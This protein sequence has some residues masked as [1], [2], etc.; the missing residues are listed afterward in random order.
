MVTSAKRHVTVFIVLFNIMDPRWSAGS[1]SHCENNIWV[2]L[3]SKISRVPTP[4]FVLCV[5]L[6]TTPF[7]N[8][9]PAHEYHK[10]LFYYFSDKLLH[11]YKH[12]AGVDFFLRLNSQRKVSGAR[13]KVRIKQTAH[14]EQHTRRQRMPR[15]LF[16]S[17]G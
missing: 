13:G 17:L 16:F 8:F 1:R 14:L 10:A 2:I 5:C 12:L 7:V 15:C 9:S 4:A 6:N 3:A 11:Q